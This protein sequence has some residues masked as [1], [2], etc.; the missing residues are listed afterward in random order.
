MEEAENIL[1]TIGHSNHTPDKFLDLLKDHEISAIVDVRS[2]PYSKYCPQFNKDT[3]QNSLKKNNLH[4]LF[5]GE[6]LG[7]RRSEAN[8]YSNG[9]V[10]YDRIAKEPLFVNGL[11]RVLEGSKMMR[12]ALMCSEK[13][14]LTCHR[15]ILI[16]REALN[17]FGGIHHIL[18]DGNIETHEESEQRLLREYNL[19]N[20][21]MF[22]SFD[23]RLTDAYSKRGQTIAYQEQEEET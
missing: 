1:Y 2:S 14:P 19:H 16:A 3:L 18:E 22:M 12:V 23:D 5:L 10:Q 17:S 11:D 9:K 7:A 13:D 6:E 21:D 20:E 4:Y 8:C 15:S